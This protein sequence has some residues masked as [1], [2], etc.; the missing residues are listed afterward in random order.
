M[1]CF[2]LVFRAIGNMV[3][4]LFWPLIPYL[5]MLIVIFYWAAS[6]VY[7]A[8]TGDAQNSAVNKTSYIDG[9]GEVVAWVDDLKKRVP[10]D[11]GVSAEGCWFT[12]AGGEG[13]Y[14][15]LLLTRIVTGDQTQLWQEEGVALPLSHM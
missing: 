8:T 15:S 13:V 2:F 5:L 3:F 7:L 4:V 1:A 10:C 6:A 9:D 14:R 11:P 12:R